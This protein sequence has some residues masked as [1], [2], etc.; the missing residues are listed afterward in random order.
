MEL[1]LFL[2][3]GEELIFE[4]VTNLEQEPYAT[5]LITFN[6]VSVEDGKK[7]T[8]IFRFNS[9]VGIS[10]DKEGFDVNSLF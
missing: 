4:N 7:K 3:S 10:V 8:A 2:E 9:L 1:T 5:G 6:Y